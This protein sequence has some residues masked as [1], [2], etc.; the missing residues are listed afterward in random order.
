MGATSQTKEQGMIVRSLE[1]LKALGQYAENPGVWTSSRYLLARDGCG[2]T[3]TQTTI[4]AG[5]RYPMEYK[6]HIEANLIVDGHGT[7]TD[8]ATGQEHALSPGVMYALDKHDRHILEAKTDLRVVCVFA[9]A[10]VGPET[11][12]EDGSYPVLDSPD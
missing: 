8:V 5:Q 3:V 12:D 11:H 6:N 7:V 2:F 1:A 4:A 9:P 10:L